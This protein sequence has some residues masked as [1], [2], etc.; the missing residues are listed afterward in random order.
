MAAYVTW[1]GGPLSLRWLAEARAVLPEGCEVGETAERGWARGWLRA[2]SD[3]V[4]SAALA[5][6]RGAGLWRCGGRWPEG[7][8]ACPLP[9]V[10]QPLPWSLGS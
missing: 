4:L 10:G 8:P 6:L 7:R 2:E 1:N 3:E 5:A 9:V